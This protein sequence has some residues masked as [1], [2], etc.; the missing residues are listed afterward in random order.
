MTS[1]TCSVFQ[2]VSFPPPPDGEGEVEP[3]TV[4]RPQLFMLPGAL[5]IL[6]SALCPLASRAAPRYDAGAIALMK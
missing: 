4:N 6:S 2:R 3:A 1:L 5:R